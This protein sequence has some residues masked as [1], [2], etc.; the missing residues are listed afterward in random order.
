MDEREEKKI[1][2][3]RLKRDPRRFKVMHIF[4][5]FLIQ[6]GFLILFKV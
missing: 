1:V 4:A 3:T 2:R 5:Q 6:K